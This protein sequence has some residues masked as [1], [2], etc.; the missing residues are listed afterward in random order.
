M[1]KFPY[2]TW[3]CFY[4]AGDLLIGHFC[5]DTEGYFTPLLKYDRQNNEIYDSLEVTGSAELIPNNTFSL[6][7]KLDFWGGIINNETGAEWVSDNTGMMWIDNRAN[8]SE[9]TKNRGKFV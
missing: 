3:D 4:P 9:D 2:F 8:A 1:D 7:K 6:Q 5:R